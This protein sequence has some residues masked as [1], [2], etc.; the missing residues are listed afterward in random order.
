MVVAIDELHE[1][2]ATEAA[3]LLQRR[4]I[5]TEIDALG[6]RLRSEGATTAVVVGG[7]RDF[8]VSG[9]LTGIDAACRSASC[10][11]GLLT[12]RN[13]GAMLRQA[14]RF[15]HTDDSEGSH[16][17]VDHEELTGFQ[18]QGDDVW[19]ETSIGSLLSAKHDALTLHC[20]GSGGH[21][22]CGNHV[23]CGLLDEFEEADGQPVPGCGPNRCKY[24]TV[25]VVRRWKARELRATTVAVMACNGVID[26][27]QLYPSNVSL[28][29]ALV[30]GHATNV[31]GLC[32]K[33]AD[34]TEDDIGSLVNGIARGRPLGTVAR[35]LEDGLSARRESR[36]RPTAILLG[37]P[38]FR[39]RPTPTSDVRQRPVSGFA[40]ADERITEELII[41]CVRENAGRGVHGVEFHRIA[42]LSRAASTREYADGGACPNCGCKA[43][44]LYYQGAMVV[45][46]RARVICPRCGVLRDWRVDGPMLE[47]RVVRRTT[48]LSWAA[49][50][51]AGP[52][53]SRAC[54]E[55]YVSA[56]DRVTGSQVASY[57]D[58]SAGAG[59]T[60]VTLDVPRSIS[61]ELHTVSGVWLAGD[62]F[63][64]SHAKTALMPG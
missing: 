4:L 53:D 58:P 34:V 11:W 63:A 51:H 57:A 26:A 27:A 16:G 20:H 55:L 24:A 17:L 47:I 10:T 54:G 19:T 21:G 52:S 2:V 60:T 59:A 61:Y 7:L 46:P 1:R 37:D 33:E 18:M 23:F 56:Q 3:A 42:D 40:D 8:E 29:I 31:I 35:R 30:E 36:S 22:V 25:D 48:E 13:R 49:A 6:E 64:F 28:A 50:V 9:A 44:V 62:T 39:H 45:E 15:L 41:S 32:T 5:R 38:T 12:G 43:D 14:R